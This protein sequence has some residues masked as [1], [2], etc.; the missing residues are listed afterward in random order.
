MKIVDSLVS[1]VL[2]RPTGNVDPR[3]T[4]LQLAV[5]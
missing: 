5:P 3:A 1:F 2:Q 4:F